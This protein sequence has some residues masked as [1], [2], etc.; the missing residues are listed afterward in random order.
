M[1]QGNRDS[2]PAINTDLPTK[3]TEKVVTSHGTVFPT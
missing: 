3:T 2:T 1:N